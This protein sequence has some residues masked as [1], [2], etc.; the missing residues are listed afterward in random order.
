MNH[1]RHIKRELEILN[2]A[3]LFNDHRTE[4]V[5]K[6]TMVFLF[7]IGGITYGEIACIR[8][9]AKRY[10]KEIIIATTN[11]INS[12]NIINTFNFKQN[13]ETNIQN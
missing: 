8:W 9:L 13:S 12:D 4:A 10:N 6:K 1:W 11:I 5:K 7:Y 3:T 2:G